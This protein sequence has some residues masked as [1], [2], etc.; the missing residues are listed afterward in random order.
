MF[1]MK[2]RAKWDAWK[3]VEGMV[4]TILDMKYKYTP[5]IWGTSSNLFTENV[6]IHVYLSSIF[7]FG[8]KIPGWSYEWLY[9]QGETAA[10][11]S[12]FILMACITCSI[13]EIGCQMLCTDLFS[14]A[15]CLIFKDLPISWRK[16]Y[17]CIKLLWYC[18]GRMAY[19]YGIS[20][21]VS[22]NLNV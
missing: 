8:R 21:W 12:S 20:A 15:C 16:T 2:D 3:A 11:S 19:F 9:Y 5:L 14:H 7:F 4:F 6:F 17:L 13:S 10:G 18:Y 1:N 22:Y